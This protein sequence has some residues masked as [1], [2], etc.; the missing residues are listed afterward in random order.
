MIKAAIFDLDGT[1]INSMPY[2][3][4]GLLSILD[5]NGISYNRDEMIGIITPSGYV[6]S[7]KHFIK[8]G[9]EGTVETITRKMTENLANDYANNIEL[10]PF[11]KEYL[12]KLK[13]EGVRLYV[14]TASPH[15]TTDPC[16]KNNGIFHLF[17]KVWSVED[18]GLSKNDMRL[19]YDAA[20]EIE[21]TPQEIYFFDDNRTAVENSAKAGYVTVGVRDLQSDNDLEII[22][23]TAYKFIESFEELI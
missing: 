19:F 1:L 13:A 18:F 4:K 3:I 8:L 17:D 21:L 5:E 6:G 9:V 15:S 10:K 16:L 2:Y 22:K 11:V 14:L 7:A 20:K 23:N 12:L